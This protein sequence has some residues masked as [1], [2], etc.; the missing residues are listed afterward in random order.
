MNK[1]LHPNLFVFD[2][3]R[4]ADG[5]LFATGGDRCR[6]LGQWSWEKPDW[7]KQNEGR[8]RSIEDVLREE[9]PT[10]LSVEAEINPGA[11]P[12][13]PANSSSSPEVRNDGNDKDDVASADPLL[14]DR[15]RPRES[16][17]LPT[18][19][20]ENAEKQKPP[21]GIARST[22][23]LSPKIMRIV[24]NSLRKRPIRYLAA[25]AAGI[26][27]KT[28][29]YWIR[30]SEAGDDGY[31][32]RWQGITQRF[33]EH[34][35]SAIDE[36]HQ[37][38]EDEWLRRAI[39]GLSAERADEFVRDFADFS[40]GTV[41]SDDGHAPGVE[42]GRPGDT[43]RRVRI[44]STFGTMAVLVTDGHLPYPYGR[45]ITGYEVS[46]LSETLS[47]AKAAGATVIVEPYIAGQ[48][49]AAMVEFPG[50]Y[51]AEIHSSTRN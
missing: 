41:T 26:H 48:R 42:I 39:N 25:L 6:Y 40:Q 29:A 1:Q 5:L 46:N 10:M 8:Y 27:P 2:R 21:A 38:L 47:K 33:H 35:E 43:Y 32:I 28:L 30:R 31:D 44:D 12:A 3:A 4:T 14:G 11:G 34:C 9:A 19:V 15:S 36:A 18:L 16:T 17:P 49:Y 23:K 24:L 37:K 13:K 20:K 22:P 45:E 50:G 51:I 7:L